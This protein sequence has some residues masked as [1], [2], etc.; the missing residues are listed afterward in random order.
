MIKQGI[1]Q[2][3][4]TPFNYNHNDRQGKF[5]SQ[6]CHYSSKKEKAP[7]SQCRKEFVRRK[8]DPRKTCSNL[9]FAISRGVRSKSPQVKDFFEH[10][11]SEKV[12]QLSFLGKIFLKVRETIELFTAKLKDT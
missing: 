6:V 2:Q 10:L 3:C 9:C 7:C 8:K 5:C 11:R 4:S 1:C 12:G